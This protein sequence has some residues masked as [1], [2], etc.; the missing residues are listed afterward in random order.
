MNFWNS[1]I[2]VSGKESIQKQRNIPTT[3]SS[4]VV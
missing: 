3:S 4:R 2:G 1:G